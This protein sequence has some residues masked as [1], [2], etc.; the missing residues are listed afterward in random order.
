MIRLSTWILVGIAFV[1]IAPVGKLHLLQCNDAIFWQRLQISN[2]IPTDSWKFLTDIV[3]A[4]NFQICLYFS[5]MKILAPNFAFLDKNFRTR[6][7]FASKFKQKNFVGNSPCASLLSS[8]LTMTS[9]M[10]IT[11][12]VQWL[13]FSI[14]TV[15]QN[16]ICHP[17]WKKSNILPL[18]SR[19]MWWNEQCLWR[20]NMT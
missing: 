20:S 11:H 17:C 18:V 1:T 6:K 19:S 9:L 5:R 3:D 15:Y 2:R 7:R 4:Q 14:P 10:D 12:S 8:P 16:H 13:S